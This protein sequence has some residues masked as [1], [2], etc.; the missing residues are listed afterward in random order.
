[1]STSEPLWKVMH[2]AR[3]DAEPMGDGWGSWTEYAAE[4]RVIADWL[5]PEEAWL[6]TDETCYAHFSERRRMR[7]RLLAEADRAEQGEE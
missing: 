7:Q 6:G 2:D 5:V 1:M 3:V 4:L